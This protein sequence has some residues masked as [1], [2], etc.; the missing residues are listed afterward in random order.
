MIE[1]QSEKF[2]PVLAIIWIISFCAFC[3]RPINQRNLL[4]TRLE[5]MRTR[6][7]ELKNQWRESLASLENQV[8]HLNQ[9]ISRDAECYLK[10]HE[11]DQTLIKYLK[12]KVHIVS[13]DPIN[14]FAILVVYL[15]AY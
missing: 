8:V 7:A 10:Q 12:D 5:T 3:S 15:S 1:A 9:K 2:R 11:E 14:V 13:V 6:L 4:T